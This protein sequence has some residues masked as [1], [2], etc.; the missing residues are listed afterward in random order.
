ME[1]LQKRIQNIKKSIRKLGGE[2]KEDN[3]WSTV[4]SIVCETCLG[5]IQSGGWFYVDF[6]HEAVQDM[7]SRP[8]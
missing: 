5:R 2:D 6:L 3:P 4:T 7:C 8:K 1:R